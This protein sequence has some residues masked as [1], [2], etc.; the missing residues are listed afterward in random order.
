MNWDIR[1]TRSQSSIFTR[2]R[3]RQEATNT[4]RVI[5]TQVNNAERTEY[6]SA[7][8]LWHHLIYRVHASCKKHVQQ[9]SRTWKKPFHPSMKSSNR[10]HIL[11][12]TSTAVESHTN[13]PRC[14]RVPGIYLYQYREHCR[15]APSLSALYSC[16]LFWSTAE[17]RNYGLL[18]RVQYSKRRW[19]C[20]VWYNVPT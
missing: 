9:V 6:S 18:V 1:T 16:F 3:S 4:T 20:R 17:I 11:P 19:C 14:W 2:I 10:Y 12:N 7:M 5:H 15:D 8:K 13:K